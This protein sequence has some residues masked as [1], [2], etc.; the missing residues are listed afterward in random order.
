M[1]LSNKYTQWY[2]SI[3]DRAKVRILEG[4]TERHHIIPKSLGGNNSQDNLVNLT[5]REHYIVHHLLT[6]MLTGDKKYKMIHAFWYMS[7][8]REQITLTSGKYE[9]IRKI[10]SETQSNTSKN[11]WKNEEY[12]NKLKEIHTSEEYIKK[13]SDKKKEKWK[14]QEYR[15]KQENVRKS[16]EFRDN[17]SAVRKEKCSSIAFSEWSRNLHTENWYVSHPIHTNGEEILIT[18]LTN[19]CKENGLSQGNMGSVAKGK[20]KHHKNWTCRKSINS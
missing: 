16:V 2:Y 15:D 8:S 5:V 12:R 3:I 20:R 11:N 14:T 18:H 1:Y 13:Q 19:F 6:K 17:L 10:Y 7:T 9:K 4:Y